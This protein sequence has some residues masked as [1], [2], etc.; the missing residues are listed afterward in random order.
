MGREKTRERQRREEMKKGENKTKRRREETHITKHPKKKVN[1]LSPT[2]HLTNN[3]LHTQEHTHK[4]FCVVLLIMVCI[5]ARSKTR[6]LYEPFSE[7]WH[8]RFPRLLT[9]MLYLWMAFLKDLYISFVHR[10][11]SRH[12]FRPHCTLWLLLCLP[13]QLPSVP[14][15]LT[16]L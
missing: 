12:D 16:A 7:Q 1:D 14:L 6:D 13:R 15:F 2:K 9:T 5:R 8:M 10:S 3:L 4:R 11:Q